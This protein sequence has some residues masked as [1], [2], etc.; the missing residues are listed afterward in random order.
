M[1][2]ELEL[3][4]E[5]LEL[6]P[7]SIPSTKKLLYQYSIKSSFQIS[8]EAAVVLKVK[9]YGAPDGMLPIARS[10]SKSSPSFLTFI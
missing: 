6:D 8:P 10:I 7:N 2:E 4:L 5:E 1:L 9:V 3:M